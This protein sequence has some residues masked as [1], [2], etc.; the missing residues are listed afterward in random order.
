VPTAVINNCGVPLGLVLTPTERA[1]SYQVLWDEMELDADGLAGVFEKAPLSDGGTGLQAY[2][3]RHARHYGCF[4]HLLEGLGSRT[5]VAILARRLMFT[6]RGENYA[7]M[8]AQA[9]MSL[10]LAVGTGIITVR[11]AEK[12]CAMFGLSDMGDGT[13]GLL[14]QDP[15]RLQALWGGMAESGVATCSNHVEGLHSNLN[16]C[17]ASTRLLHRR[18]RQI[19][20][21]LTLKA[22][23]F[24]EQAMRSA[25]AKFSALLAK[26]M[27]REV[28]CSASGVCDCGW[29]EIYAARFGLARFPCVHLVLD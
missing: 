8:R 17:V 15:F 27:A 2:G 21:A 29:G 5:F 19:I 25:R 24:R 4:R 3:R 10:G 22:E 6:A 9:A 7:R 1:A 26:A 14:D 23:K 18:I 12:F 11:G 16:R 20:D 28:H 13:F